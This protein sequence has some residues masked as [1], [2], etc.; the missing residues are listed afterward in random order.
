MKVL[1]E[2][3]S[4]FLNKE[5]LTTIKILSKIKMHVDVDYRIVAWFNESSANFSCFGN[6]KFSKLQK[7]LTGKHFK[8]Y[9][10]L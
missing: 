5:S 6:D 3:D 1:E 4:T 8:R 10:M 9:K 2:K 7:I